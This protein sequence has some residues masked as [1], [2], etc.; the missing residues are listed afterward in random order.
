MPISPP[1]RSPD[2][3]SLDFGCG[4]GASTAV[5][6]RLYPTARFVGVELFPEY[7]GIAEARRVF[8]GSEAIEFHVS[9]S[10]T[11]LP[12]GL[13]RFG[14]VCLSAVYEHLLPE[15]RPAIIEALWSAVAPGG[16]LL[17]NQTPDRR[18]PIEQHTTGLPLLNYLPDRLAFAAARRF[19]GRVADAASPESLLR[20]GIRG[21]TPREIDAHLAGLGAFVRLRPTR[22]GY[23]RQGQIWYRIVAGRGGGAGPARR[24][25]GVADRLGVPWAPYLSLAYRKP[26]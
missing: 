2:S 17:V 26:A 23:R 10:G 1:T 24:A 22:L 12:Q 16:V 19:S 8:H 20:E 18:F 3:A 6:A 9:P 25:L 13:G 14:V 5:L 4:S 11:E 7:V 21:G 15:E